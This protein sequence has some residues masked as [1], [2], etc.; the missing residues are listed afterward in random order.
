MDSFSWKNQDSYL[1]FGIVIN[2]KPPLVRAEKNVDEIEIQGRDGDLTVDFNTYKPITFPFI[3]T[4]LDETRIDEVLSWLDG[5]SDL[6]LS[7]QNDRKYNAKMI[8]RIDISQSLETFGEFPLLFK[9]Q[10]F[11]YALNNDLI[12]LLATPSTV[13]NTATKDSKPVIKVYGTGTIDLIVNGN[14]IH[15]T[16]VVSYVT[17]DSVMEDA[18]KDTD[19]KNNDMAGGFPLLVVGSNTISWTGA[20]TKVEIT[21]NWRFL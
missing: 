4:L 1:D 14:L 2:M 5:Y 20:V 19:P 9:A 12:T 6:I 18:Y 16:N 15:L 13:T 17:I 10:P 3:C 11:G 8:N 7:W 21:P